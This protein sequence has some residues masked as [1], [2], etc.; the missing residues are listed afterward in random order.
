[1]A[2][3]RSGR[4]PRGRDG[5]AG[6]CSGSGPRM[7]RCP[8]G[9]SRCSPPRP[10]DP[11]ASPRHPPRRAPA[12]ATPL[13]NQPARQQGASERAVASEIQNPSEQA[14][15]QLLYVPSRPVPGSPP[16]ALFPPPCSSIRRAARSRPR[17]IGRLRLADR[18]SSRKPHARQEGRGKK[19]RL[20]SAPQLLPGDSSPLPPE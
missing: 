3:R 8:C 6:G 14:E 16:P 1:M 18:R 12:Y 15:P 10:A 19:S 7:R 2:H 11:A 20:F 9:G 13:R 17:A 4:S 5:R